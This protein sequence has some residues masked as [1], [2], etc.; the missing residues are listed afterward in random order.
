MEEPSGFS[1]LKLACVEPTA[2][3]SYRDLRRLTL[4]F[5]EKQFLVGYG[6][7]NKTG[8]EKMITAERLQE[9]YQTDR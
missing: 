8:V 4:I 1:V 2:G 3:H 9:G 7:S 6:V 5:S